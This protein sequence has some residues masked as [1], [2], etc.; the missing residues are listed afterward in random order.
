[1]PRLT[2]F[3]AL[4]VP[5]GVLLRQGHSWVLRVSV[6]PQPQLETVP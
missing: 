2:I 1:M 5:L 6:T 3:L 4:G